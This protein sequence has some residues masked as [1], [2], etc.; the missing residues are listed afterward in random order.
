MVDTHSSW[1]QKS[2][3]QQKRRK[4]RSIVFDRLNQRSTFF[5]RDLKRHDTTAHIVLNMNPFP[6]ISFQSSSTLYYY[7]IPEGEKQ[8]WYDEKDKERFKAEAQRDIFT[9]WRMKG[10]LANAQATSDTHCRFLCLV[11]LERHLVSPEF[12]TKLLRTRKLVEHAVLSEQEK[13]D[14]DGNKAERIAAAARRHSEWSAAKAK[15]FG[16]F[17]HNQSK[18]SR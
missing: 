17:Q 11:G 6:T 18:E 2:H 3:K 13:I 14:T 5:H 12:S 16:D 1:L 10:G 9:F 7:D 4:L 8:E 15:M